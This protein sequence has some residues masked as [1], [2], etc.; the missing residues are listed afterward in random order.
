MARFT[1]NDC[2]IYNGKYSIGGDHNEVT[3]T[4]AVDTPENTA[5]GATM[6][7]FLAGG[8]TRVTLSGA[9]FWDP[10]KG[11]ID[12]II[13]TRLGSAAAD[14]PITL[15]AAPTDGQSVAIPGAASRIFKSI[16]TSYAIG[17]TVGDAAPFTLEGAGRTDAYRATVMKEATVTAAGDGVSQ[18][19]GAL[20]VK[21]AM[22]GLLHVTAITDG[23][24]TVSIESSPNG[25]DTWT[26]RFAFLGAAAAT[27]QWKEYSTAQTDAY[28]RASWTYAGTTTTFVV[29]VAIK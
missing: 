25:T 14:E 7:V 23:T 15:I 9:G 6:H 18:N 17:G 2:R 5:F 3:L 19:I 13:D 4:T 8:L 11:G 27:S 24:L 28:W 20:T 12:D 1:F 10:V 26:S 29:S 16:T 22:Y 21:A